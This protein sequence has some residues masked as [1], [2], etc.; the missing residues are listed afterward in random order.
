M[1]K[2]IKNRDVLLVKKTDSSEFKV[3]TGQNTDGTPK[4]TLPKE[5][6][7]SDFLRI[8]EQ[9]DVL[10]KF[11]SDFL[12]R[13]KEPE[14]FTFHKAAE[15]GVEATVCFLKEV[16]DDPETTTL[17]DMNNFYAHAVYP[18]AYVQKSSL[19]HGM[20]ESRIGRSVDRR[21]ME[22]QEKKERRETPKQLRGRK[23]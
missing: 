6:N 21:G 11:F 4:T 17:E 8:D 2:K 3:V 13:V 18:P 22:K 19:N 12:R 14:R 16:M 15:D 23:M 10:R 5:E 9:G 7:R 20:D 1:D